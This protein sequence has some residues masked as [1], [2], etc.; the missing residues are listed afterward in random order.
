MADAFQLKL[1][2]SETAV[3]RLA[4]LT[5]KGAA[6]A[7]VGGGGGVKLDCN[8]LLAVPAGTLEIAPTTALFFRAASTCAVVDPG[9]FSM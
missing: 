2:V 3:A 9:L 5:C 4:G 7:V 6:G 8:N 1:A